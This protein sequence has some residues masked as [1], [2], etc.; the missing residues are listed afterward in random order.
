MSDRPRLRPQMIGREPQ[1]E[2]LMATLSFALAS[3][4]S[5]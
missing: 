4:G 3:E 2:W 1:M 5:A